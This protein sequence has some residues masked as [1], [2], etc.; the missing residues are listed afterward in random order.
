VNKGHI[1][2]GMSAKQWTEDCIKLCGAGK[3]GGK[4]DQA[5]AIFSSGEKS[6]REISEKAQSYASGFGPF[7][8]AL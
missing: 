6:V 8:V 7:L 1:A 5:N 2:K 3:G 4:D